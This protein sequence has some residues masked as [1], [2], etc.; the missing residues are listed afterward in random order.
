MH[1]HR[2][3]KTGLVRLFGMKYCDAIKYGRFGHLASTTTGQHERFC[4]SQVAEQL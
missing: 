2:A 4:I 3:E 1:V